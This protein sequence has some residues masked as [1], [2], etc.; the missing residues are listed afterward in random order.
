MRLAGKIF[1][2]LFRFFI[3]FMYGLYKSLII[4][5]LSINLSV[6]LL[7]NS[8]YTFAAS[9]CLLH[10]ELLSI[11]TKSQSDV[12]CIYL[13]LL[14][15]YSF[16]THSPQFPLIYI[17]HL[18]AVCEMSTT[19]VQY[20]QKNETSTSSQTYFLVCVLIFGSESTLFLCSK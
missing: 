17:L 11:Y 14:Q 10:W 13:D 6:C 15:Q 7:N 18:Q 2:L 1:K 5:N 16:W 4:E 19:I 12:L 8:A 3:F 20:C 9:E